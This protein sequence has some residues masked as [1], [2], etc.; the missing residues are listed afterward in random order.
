LGPIASVYSQYVETEVG[1]EI[2][3][4]PRMTLDEL[5]T[6]IPKKAIIVVAIGWHK[7]GGRRA[8][9]GFVA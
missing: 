5:V 1:N 9:L 8:S 6:N 2:I 3:T 7:N 4:S